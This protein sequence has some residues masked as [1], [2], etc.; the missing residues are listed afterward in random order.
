MVRCLANTVFLLSVICAQGQWIIK[1][2]HDHRD[3]PNARTTQQTATP[4]PL[5]FWDDFSQAKNVPDSTLW[6]TG[7]DIFVNNTLGQNAPTQGVATFDGLRF[8]GQAHSMSANFNGAGDSLVSHPIDLSTVSS[9][10]RNTVYLSFYWQARGFGEIPDEDDS[11]R[12][13]LLAKIDTNLV[14]ESRWMQRGGLENVKDRFTFE[15]IQINEDKFFH[16]DFRIKFQ[17]FSS[18][19]GPFD[20]WNID[21][22]Y[23]NE[24]RS[25][26]D[27][28]FIDRSPS[29]SP[30]PLFG[31]YY[32]VT[33]TAF[34]NNPERV[35]SP[36]I[37]SISNLNNQPQPADV[38][39]SII[40][41]NTQE[42]YLNYQLPDIGLHGAGEIKL[43]EG[44]DPQAVG[45]NIP[46]FEGD[47]LVISS[48]FLHSTGDS[49]LYEIN[50]QNERIY[51]SINL[52]VNDTLRNFYTLHDTYAYDDGVAEFASGINT[53]RGQ[54]AMRYV[55]SEP[56]TLTHVDIY[57]PNIA[58]D[59]T[60]KNVDIIVWSRLSEDH[61]LSRTPHTI[62][63]P[64]KLNQF[65]RIKLSPPVIVRD[66]IYIGY[67]QFIDNY[68][69]V[70]FDRNNPLGSEH[71]FSN[72]EADWEQNTRLSGVLMIRPVFGEAGVIVLAEEPK[73]LEKPGIYPNPTS[74]M[75]H[76]EGK[77]E[78]LAIFDLLGRE[79]YASGYKNQIDL[80]FLEDGIYLLKINNKNSIFT[81]KVIIRK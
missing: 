42:V 34:F 9:F 57:F 71:I 18:L 55:V 43:A 53:I 63:L 64:A 74:G 8:T 70:G 45:V 12:L 2:I 16:E 60:G 32:Q 27:S 66:T 30:G 69:G 49:L 40:N 67:Q 50:A 25:N 13:Q 19:K 72:V 1:P 65:T 6:E 59:A 47:S 48:T 4:V 58:P 24:N 11:L 36:Q 77:Y 38:R 28:V 81:Q 75:I 37:I 46:P 10:N 78:E 41:E 21:Y 33:A 14:W 17:S 29:V 7:R 26:N 20:T 3:A 54:V 39:Y 80:R 76:L 22:V 79:V 56:D 51:S 44:P 62:Q 5:P 61:E 68:I 35:L 15:D 73:R 52:R 31:T 23:L